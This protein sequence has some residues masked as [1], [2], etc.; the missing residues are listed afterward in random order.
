LLKRNRPTFVLYWEC[1]VFSATYDLEVLNILV[2]NN[3]T[4]TFKSYY[5]L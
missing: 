4:K 3:I 5:K 2:I 1:S